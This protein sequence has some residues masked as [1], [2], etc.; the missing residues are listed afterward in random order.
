MPTR[1]R[2]G[3]PRAVLIEGA[4]AGAGDCTGAGA[5][6]VAGAGAGDDADVPLAAVDDEPSPPPQAA[7]PALRKAI[8]TRRAWDR[9]FSAGGILFL[10]DE[11]CLLVVL[12]RQ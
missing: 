9:V 8:A 7:T 2:P 5:G 11:V 4:G 1:S 10:L 12:P 3:L 6:A